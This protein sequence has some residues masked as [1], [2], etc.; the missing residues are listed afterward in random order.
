MKK[1]GLIGTGISQ[2]GSPALFKAA[3]KGKYAYDLLDGTDFDSLFHTFVR[4]YSAVNVTSP[5]KTAAFEKADEATDAAELCGAANMLIK[6]PDGKIL[7]DNSDFEGVTMS[8]MSAYA[9]SEEDIDILDEDA[10]SDF[11]SDKTALVAGCSG[12]GKAAAAAAVTMGYGRTILMNRD[13]SRAEATE[14][15]IRDYFG[16]VGKDEL[17]VWDMDRF[18]EA[19]M[20]A[21]TVI[22]TIPQAL[23][24][25]GKSDFA[26]GLKKGRKMILEANYQ[27]PCLEFLR[28]RCQ[29]VSGLNWLFNQA[30][31]A[32]EAFTGEE[33]DEEAMKKAL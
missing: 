11:L 30:V 33:P 29:Y 21:D 8:I 32:Y 24:C 13:R 6:R 16:D 2:S 28:D 23:D 3:F 31:V 25:I 20:E 15:H 10:F 9:V 7:A 4:D 27:M 14:K 5:F 22:Y 19:F 18:E 12:A 1:F 17:T 26:A